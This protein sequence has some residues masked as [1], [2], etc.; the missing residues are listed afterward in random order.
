MPYDRSFALNI[1]HPT[2]SNVIINANS[3]RACLLTN[4][5]QDPIC[6][7][8]GT[9]LATIT[10]CTDSGY[11]VSLLPT[12]WKALSI[13]SAAGTA[14]AMNTHI[15]VQNRALPEPVSFPHSQA[16]MPAL[17]AKFE[18]LPIVTATLQSQCQSPIALLPDSATAKSPTLISDAVFNI[19]QSSANNVPQAKPLVLGS[20]HTNLLIKTPSGAPEL[21]TKHSV[22]IYTKNHSIALRFKSI[23]NKYPAI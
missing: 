22:H 11:F 16:I 8:K 1:V 3:S 5:T 19:I 4:P 23:I 20:V 2:A 15:L 21:V 7:S 10:E 13:A 17:G 18:L 12:A 9:R 14:T 6:L